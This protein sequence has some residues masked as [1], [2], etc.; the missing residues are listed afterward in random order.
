MTLLGSE[1]CVS[2]VLCTFFRLVSR[3]P[4]MVAM[5]VGGYFLRVVRLR[6]GNGGRKPFLSAFVKLILLVRKGLHGQ[7]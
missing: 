2:F 6:P 3:C 1:A 5:D 4:L 7:N